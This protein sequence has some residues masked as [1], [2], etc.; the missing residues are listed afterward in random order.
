GEASNP[1]AG[2]QRPEPGQVVA[3]PAEAIQDL[4]TEARRDGG[5]PARARAR[6]REVIHRDS[7]R[8][9]VGLQTSDLPRMEEPEVAGLREGSPCIPRQNCVAVG[10]RGARCDG[11][12]AEAREPLL[13]GCL[14]IVE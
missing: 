10:V 14:S 12:A 7:E 6:A 4:P 11:L 2:D 13:E 8:D 5:C 1:I 3:R 9:A